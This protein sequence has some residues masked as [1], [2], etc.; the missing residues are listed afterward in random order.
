MSAILGDSYEKRAA[1][2]VGTWQSNLWVR[3]CERAISTR[4]GS[5]EW[6]LQDEDGNP[7]TQESSEAQQAVA[8]LIA[9]PYHPQE[10]DPVAASPQ[11]R[12]EQWS[13]TSRHMGVVGYG[14]WY[15]SG[16]DA[17]AG[18]PSEMLYV[19]PAR[20][21]PA[22]N[23]QGNLIGWVMDRNSTQPV[24]FDLDEIVPFN[25]EP[26]EEGFLGTGLVASALAKAEMSRL[27][28]KHANFV[29][30][31]GGR[32]A[33]MFTPPPGTNIPEEQYQ[34]IVRDLRS[35]VEM[36][37][38]SKRS[39]VL[40]GPVQ[41]T[42]T[43]ASPADLRLTDLAEMSRDDI[44]AL[45]GVPPSQLGMEA[46]AGLNSGGTKA[47]DEATLWQGAIEPRLRTITEN[48]NR[49]ILSRYEEVTGRLVLIAKPPVFDDAMPLYDM[50]AKRR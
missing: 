36:P 41:F 26:P 12:K 45:W 49:L 34:A 15:L 14:F 1:Q 11:T 18:L 32:L 4:L 29:L 25:L 2:A 6:E 20:M 48:Y 38:A 23:A 21:S 28:D 27:T 40:K 37:D 19:H 9:R 16:T 50:A 3:A 17:L 22:T 42:E 8:Q 39:L 33:G 46:P 24:G 47:Y 31:S 10:G 7:I 5:V 44:L 43:A 30:S 13:L 35:I